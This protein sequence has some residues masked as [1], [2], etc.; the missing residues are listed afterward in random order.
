MIIQFFE[1]F[2]LGSII[3]GFISW[4]YL[5]RKLKITETEIINAKEGLGRVTHDCETF[6]TQLTE[7]EEI[8][9]T[10][11][12]RIK[13]LE[14]EI[15]DKRVAIAELETRRG[16]QQKHFE[17]K[18]KFLNE[19]RSELT[20]EFSVL[21]NKILEENG[22]VFTI[23]NRENIDMV[24]SPL[25]EQIGEFKKRVEDVHLQQETSRAALVNEIGNL[26]SLGLKISTDATN[27]TQ[28]LKG[29]NKAQGNWGELVL[30]KVLEQSGLERGRE[31][32]TQFQTIDANGERYIPD[33]IVRLPMEKDVV[34]DAK[35]S[36]LA[37]EKYCSSENALEQEI[38]LDTHTQSIKL[39]IKTLSEKRYENLQEIRSLDL[40]IMFIP[41]E[42]AFIAAIKHDPNIVS[43][44]FSKN[45]ILCCP[46]LLLV[47]LKTI[48]WSW[49]TE[50]QNRNVMEIARKAGDLYDK[51]CGFLSTL[52]DIGNNI[53][54][55]NDSYENAIKI[56]STG[57]GNL[58]RRAQELKVLGVNGKKEIPDK[59]LNMTDS[60]LEQARI[61]G[62]IL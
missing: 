55:S 41:I 39:H 43:F 50:N 2:L 12:Q 38:A 53:R 19:T 40:V 51:F 29:D 5:K 20:N 28:A 31:F 1:W 13:D 6:Q 36:L 18:L 42:S 25:R 14:S 30:E 49:R 35:A 37:F 57:K 4:L 32:E 3:G 48:A 8:T 27:L 11:K 10:N 45:I 58:I 62:E 16:E 22:K 15:T 52:E 23:Q 34:I 47:V 7:C 44:A 54:K 56:L 59:F 26:K 24:L 61:E 17:E 33:A 9:E 46:S 60:V 21:A